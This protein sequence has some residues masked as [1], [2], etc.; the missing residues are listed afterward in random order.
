[1][2]GIK[3]ALRIFAMLLALVCLL[4]LASCGE[5]PTP[6][7]GDTDST[8]DGRH[9]HTF[10]SEWEK[11]ETHHWHPA[12]CSHTRHQSD[13]GE[14][15]F[16]RGVIWQ[17]AGCES[18]GI[19]RYTC[20]VCGGTKDEPYAPKGH[21]WGEFEVV[22]PAG[23]TTEGERARTC[24]RCGESETEPI[25]K[26]DHRLTDNWSY[27]ESEH[28]RACLCGEHTEMAE[29]T[30]VGGECEVCWALQGAI[31]TN[32]LL[33]SIS[34]DGKY[35]IVKGVGTLSDENLRAPVIPATYK[36]LPV[37]EI[38]DSAFRGERGIYSIV[39]P[40]HITYIGAEAFF[41][42]ENLSRVSIGE[43]VKIIGAAAFSGCPQLTSVSVSAANTAFMSQSGCLIRSSDK[44]LISSW[45]NGTIPDGVVSIG[46]KAFWAAEQLTSL[47]IP[48]SV[49]TIGEFA[50]F[51][52]SGLERVAIPDGVTEIGAYAFSGCS[53]M[54]AIT[55]P[56]TLQTLGER[57]LADC[58]ALQN[59][60]LPG[61]LKTIGASCFHACVALTA[62]DIPDSVTSIGYAPFSGCTGLTTI[63]VGFNNQHYYSEGNCL[64]YQKNRRVST[65]EDIILLAG[66]STSV[67]PSNTMI[68]ETGAFF[69]ITGLTSVS[70]PASVT[71]IAATAFAECTGITSITLGSG[72]VTIGDCA[73]GGCTALCEIFIPKNVQNMGREVFSGCTSLTTIRCAVTIVP[74]G[75]SREWRT[76]CEATA[77]YGQSK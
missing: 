15:T 30:F 67:I 33:F 9:V 61:G 10:S 23:C 40:A 37:T 59:I 60:A 20:T 76:G 28:W 4:A 5:E 8:E 7:G 39:I 6:D 49:K 58:S 35:Y 54:R 75:W 62:I 55:L 66:C 46:K 16:D 48:R 43:G 56:S 53:S 70:L 25:A 1:M 42:C 18:E 57:A 31:V 21:A 65:I 64:M 45:G 14:H 41:G 12:T 24:D 73:F 68:I 50:F 47:S 52:C 2:R 29:H 3:L 51:G 63:T 19:I 77:V 22:I 69:G 26:T 13:Y 27:N 71:R 32:E 44:C 74:D 34:D 36:G 72:L 11:D 17:Q 38:A